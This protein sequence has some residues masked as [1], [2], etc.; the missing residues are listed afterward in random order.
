MKYMPPKAILYLNRLNKDNNYKKQITRKLHFNIDNIKNKSFK[1]IDV[2]IHTWGKK[3]R[4][5]YE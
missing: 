1:E 4:F 5:D 3:Y 2:K